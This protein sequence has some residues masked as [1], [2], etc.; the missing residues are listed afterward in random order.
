MT[1]V[2]SPMDIEAFFSK[3]GDYTIEMVL[4]GRQALFADG[5]SLSAFQK[6][7]AEQVAK[8]DEAEESGQVD[9]SDAVAAGTGLYLV[10]K[11]RHALEVLEHAKRTKIGMLVIGLAS[12]ETRHYVEAEKYLSKV[13]DDDAPVELLC[14]LVLAKALVGDLDGAAEV[15]ATVH[16]R[17]A[18]SAWD[19]FVQGFLAEMKG[20]IGE[21]L[22][23][24]SR[25]VEANGEHRRALF[26][27][28]YNLDLRGEDDEAIAYYQKLVTM[29]PV[30]GNT[31]VNLGLLYEDSGSFRRAADCFRKAVRADVHNERARLFLRDAEA[32]MTMYYDEEKERRADKRQKVLEIPVT[33][34]ELSVRSRNCLDRMNIRTLGDLT[35][36]SE[37]E[38]LRFKN[39]GETSLQEIKDM[40]GSKGLRLGQALEDEGGAAPA[41]FEEEP[42]EEPQIVTESDSITARPIEELNLGVRARRAVDALNIRTIGDLAERS[43]TELL[44][45]KNFGQT[46]LNEIKQRLGEMGLELGE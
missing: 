30:D 20:S 22:D 6:Q 46:S 14:D 17:D 4:S 39:F 29:E 26:R 42:E 19:L 8:V 36:V 34:F 16:K 7:L 13:C 38:L 12:L 37:Q 33:D 28:A 32:S 40:L 9:S 24:Y 11:L 27:L 43:E 3:P 18:D 2:Q 21:A 10:G 41:A 44:K 1:E 5:E 23:L 45:L 25:A 35:K 15:A 31:L